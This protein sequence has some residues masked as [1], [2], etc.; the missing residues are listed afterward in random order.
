MLPSLPMPYGCVLAFVSELELIIEAFAAGPLQVARRKIHIGQRVIQ[1]AADAAG[2]PWRLR[3]QPGRIGELADRPI[4]VE[5][6]R[7]FVEPSQIFVG[8]SG[9]KQVEVLRADTDL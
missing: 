2:R 4:D 1:A 6:G 7:L 9:G 8:A 3:V 5:G